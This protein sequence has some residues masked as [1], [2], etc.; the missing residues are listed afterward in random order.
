MILLKHRDR[1]RGQEELPQD[2]EDRLIIYYGVGEG[3]I[4][5]K[6]PVRLSYAKED[7]RRLEA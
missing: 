3:K 6:F 5:G 4:Q 1:T 2:R 7:S